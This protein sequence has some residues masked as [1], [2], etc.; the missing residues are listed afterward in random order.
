M[1]SALAD[2]V[3]VIH[4]AFIAFVVFGG[5]LAIRWPWLAWLH[6]PALLWGVWIE[7]SSGICPLTPLENRLRAAAGE[8]GYG[9]GF[10]EYY[11]I[12]LIY[13]PGL[14]SGVQIVLAVGLVA[15]N[16]VAYALLVRRR[17]ALKRGSRSARQS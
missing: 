13:P 11:L 15:L 3:V 2:A 9:G 7:L 4:L 10:V 1:E 6:V 5:W 12:P 8:A 16:G 14:T 17:R